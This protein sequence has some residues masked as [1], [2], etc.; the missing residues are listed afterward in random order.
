MGVAVCSR[1][2][3]AVINTIL[4]I[5]LLNKGTGRTI[6]HSKYLYIKSCLYST[7][8]FRAPDL[9]EAGCAHRGVLQLM[10]HLY[11]LLQRGIFSPPPNTKFQAV[12]KPKS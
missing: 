9:N 6:L 8:D 4:I 10:S 2:S 7:L 11:N 12:F 1:V 3:V 5:F